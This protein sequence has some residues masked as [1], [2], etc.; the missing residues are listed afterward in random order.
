MTPEVVIALLSSPLLIAIPTLYL[1]HK[2]AQFKRNTET[3]NTSFTR[4]E[5]ENLR[6]SEQIRSLEKRIRELEFQEDLHREE[7]HLLRARVA[8]L[9]RRMIE[10]GVDDEAMTDG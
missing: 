3:A 10:L 1:R 5:T 7:I 6:L 4:L 9:R 8:E 2:D